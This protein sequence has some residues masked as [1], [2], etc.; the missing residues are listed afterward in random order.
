MENA[1]LEERNH[2]PGAQTPADLGTR[3]MRA[4]EIASSVWLNGPAWLSENEAHWSKT[5]AVCTISEGTSESSQV[6][7]LL[8]NKPLE[9]Q[10]ERFSSWT[11]LN[12]TICYVLRW[13]RSNRIKGLISMDENHNTEQIM[14]ELV[15]KEAFMTDYETLIIR[16]E[17]SSKSNIAKLIPFLDEQR[18]MRASG[19]L[20]KAHFEYD[21]KHPFFLP[22]KHPAIRLM[23][24]KCHLDNYHQG[25][26]SMRHELQQKFWILGLRKALRNIKVAASMQDI[27]CCCPSSHYG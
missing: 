9:I 19:R 2:V 8:P 13:R 5:A 16:K 10:W 12:H 23:M 26:E 7:T 3:G 20:S 14:F 27:Q 18:I 1:K 25:V 15:Q 17:L 4:N 24:L 11:K 21:T 22:S 6:V